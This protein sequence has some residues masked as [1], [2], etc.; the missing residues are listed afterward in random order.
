MRKFFFALVATLLTATQLLA[1]P[2]TPYPV[3]VTQP[4]GRE[5]TVRLNGDE[6]YHFY[7]TEDGYTIVKNEMGFFTYAQRAEGKLEPTAMV[8]VSYTHLDVYKRQRLQGPRHSFCP[9]P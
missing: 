7:T 2:A 4:D 5:L 6:F 9:D 1:V 3:K 8:A